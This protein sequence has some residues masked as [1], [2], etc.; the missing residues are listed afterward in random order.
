[1]TPAKPNAIDLDEPLRV[2]A[3]AS[4]GPWYAAEN[5][6]RGGSG[7]LVFRM[8]HRR[9]ALATV[10][11]RNAIPQLIAEHRA[12]A[13]RLRG[14]ESLPTFDKSLEF[15]M[16]GDLEKVVGQLRD[17]AVEYGGINV[18][19]AQG[20]ARWLMSLARGKQFADKEPGD[21]IL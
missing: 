18:P 6:V 3:A 11:A 9:D 20:L 15:L 17:E 5:C 12:M 7:T 14:Y 8:G 21:D 13:E 19:L 10:A 4:D 1:M 16:S 2:V